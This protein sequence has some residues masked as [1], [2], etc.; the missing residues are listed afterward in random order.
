[1]AALHAEGAAD[2]E[3][4][5]R[6]AA[7]APDLAPLLIDLPLEVIYD[8]GIG[9]AV[10]LAADTSQRLEGA[11]LERLATACWRAITKP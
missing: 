1:M 7:A 11:S 2:P 3:D 4:E 5:L 9:P 6:R 10:R 8:L